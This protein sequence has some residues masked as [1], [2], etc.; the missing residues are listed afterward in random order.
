MTDDGDLYS[1]VALPRVPGFRILGIV[2]SGG[3]GIVYRASRENDP[4]AAAVKVAHGGVDSAA[5]QLWREGDLLASIGVPAVPAV[6]DRG[7]V[8]DGRPYL[9]ME[10]IELP[11]LAEL[12]ATQPGPMPLTAFYRRALAM[13]HALSRVHRQGVAHRDL[14]PDNIF[15]GDS[16]PCARL[17]DFGIAETVTGDTVRSGPSATRSDEPTGTPGYIAPEIYWG[18]TDIDQ[19]ADIYV[20]GALFYEMLAGEKPF[21]GSSVELHQAHLARR[22]PLLSERVPVPAAVEAAIARCMEKDPSRRFDSLAALN[23][24]LQAS[25]GSPDMAVNEHRSA[26]SKPRSKRQKRT[27]GLVLLDSEISISALREVSEASSGAIAHVEDTRYVLVFAHVSGSNPVQRALHAAGQLLGRA[28]C[29]RV[30]VELGQVTVREAENRRITYFSPVFRKT[31]RYPQP[32]DPPGVSISAAAAAVLADLSVEPLAELPGWFR[33][34]EAPGKDASPVAAT[35]CADERMFVGRDREL[36]VLLHHAGKTLGDRSA[37]LALVTGEAGYGKSHLAAALLD[38]LDARAADIVALR[39]R[40]SLTGEGGYQISRALLRRLLGLA[41]DV[42]PDDGMRR[43]RQFAAGTEHGELWPALALV[44]GWLEPHSAPVKPLAAAPGALR[45]AAALLIAEALRRA[46]TRPLCI[47]VDDA[48]VADLIALDALLSATGEHSTAPI[49]TCL[50]GRPALASQRG[51]FT[52]L[53]GVAL[54]LE[55][56]EPDDASALCRHLLRPVEYVPNDAVQRIIGR[57]RRIPL[58]LVELVHELK[59]RGYVRQSRRSGEWYVATD[60]IG[61]QADLPLIEWLAEGETA[62]LTSDLRSHAQLASLIGR[63]FSSRQVARILDQL[64]RTGQGNAFPLDARVGLR[65]LVDAGLLRHC[66]DDNY[67]F[68]VGLIRD[69]IARSVDKKL[70]R[71]VHDTAYQCLADDPVDD[72]GVLARLAYHAEHA[73]RAEIAAARY[74]DAAEQAQSRHLYLDAEQCCSK[75][76]ELFGHSRPR[77]I[78]RGLRVR[79]LMRCRLGRYED[80]LDDLQRAQRIAEVLGAR[81]EQG[82]LLIEE[83]TA[84][85]WMNEYRRSSEAVEAAAALLDGKLSEPTRARLDMARGRAHFRHGDYDNSAKLLARAV[86]RASEL[87]DDCYES[88]VTALMLLAPNLSMLGQIDQSE[89]AFEQ[90][91][92][93]CVERGDRMHLAAA[94]GNRLAL[95]MAQ[96]RGEEAIATVSRALAINAELGLL[97]PQ[98]RAHYNLAE[99]WHQYGESERALPHLDRALELGKRLMGEELRPDGTLL[100]ARI[101]LFQNARAEARAAHAELVAHQAEARQTGRSEALLLP[102]EQMLMAAVGLATR[103]DFDE[104]AWEQLIAEAKIVVGQP[105]DLIEIMEMRGLAAVQCGCVSHARTFLAEALD[106]ARASTTIAEPR[107]E[108]NLARTRSTE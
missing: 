73:G 97:T 6:L 11:T 51:E 18:D 4:V 57:T 66:G 91:I 74:L 104:R 92:N 94:H 43:L 72:G 86:R 103:A 35:E 83:A 96:K 25:Q 21:T 105:G 27:M 85:D 87:G 41:G 30:R 42:S 58:L 98:Y 59:R 22:P 99:L 50:V 53:A 100:R 70:R 20:I 1:D 3:F 75:A 10:Y 102:P 76:I 56:L 9:A 77:Q 65:Q 101:H 69:A 33:P 37:G 90:L 106:L 44:M 67:E 49:W 16:P 7:T 48:H 19:R 40:E 107:I 28:R 93:L 78:L 46:A 108:K 52:E 55:P 26:V 63:V 17:I 84:L 14:K 89:R 71:Q 5:A 29:Q 23:Q 54:E 79:S 64:E 45:M 62:A 39:G 88:H 61:T 13:V 80:M 47:V 12:L 68:R 95:Y 32:S 38:R 8:Q 36:G 15:I 82:E 24:A 60:A 34:V 2:G 81:R 31:D